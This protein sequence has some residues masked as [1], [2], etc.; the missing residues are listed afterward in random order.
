MCP[1]GVLAVRED[2]RTPCCWRDELEL[3]HLDAAAEHDVGQ[4]AE[5]LT[6][7]SLH[8]RLMLTHVR[9]VGLT[10]LGGQSVVARLLLVAV[11]GQVVGGHLLQQ[12]AGRLL[13]DV[14][15]VH[16]PL[17][18]QHAVEEGV[19]S[20]LHHGP[21]VAVDDVAVGPGGRAAV[22]GLEAELP[23]PVGV[24]LVLGQALSHQVVRLQQ[25]LGL[26]LAEQAGRR[27]GVQLAR[28]DG[29]VD[30]TLRP[31]LGE[32]EVGLPSELHH[33]VG[34]AHGLEDHELPLAVDPIHPSSSAVFVLVPDPSAYGRFLL[35][36]GLSVVRGDKQ[37]ILAT[38]LL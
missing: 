15:R 10:R 13:V 8:L 14:A 4:G 29:V 28:L 12:A 30:E 16:L 32:V 5:P 24:E 2:Y 21:T 18:R 25:I 33:D 31:D 19:H 34:H 38:Y 6:Q 17:D 35:D 37:L 27:V 9:L 11:D 20:A 36:L 23:G 1:C 7:Q 3:D 22:A 26:D